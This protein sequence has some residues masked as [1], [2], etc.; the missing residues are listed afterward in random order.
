MRL[1]GAAAG[2]G[3]GVGTLSGHRCEALYPAP[4]GPGPVPVDGPGLTLMSGEGR[5]DV[6]Q[7]PAGGAGR[8]G[9]EGQRAGCRLSA[10]VDR[11]QTFLKGFE[12]T[13]PMHLWV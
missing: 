12:G 2:A 7:G 1:G 3:T 10:H 6:A 8:R 13:L 4:K 9:G 11:G 5:G